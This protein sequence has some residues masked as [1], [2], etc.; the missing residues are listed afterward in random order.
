[1]KNPACLE[2]WGACILCVS[3]QWLVHRWGPQVLPL[4]TQMEVLR[5]RL[6]GW[7]DS[8]THLGVVSFRK[9]N[10]EKAM[11]SQDAGGSDLVGC[12]AV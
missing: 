8:T 11:W 6:S 7:V 10:P 3:P 4:Q 5:S 2:T 1:M 12:N 9:H